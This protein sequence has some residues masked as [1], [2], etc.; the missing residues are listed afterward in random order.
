M[1]ILLIANTDWYLYNFRLR[2]A[3][4]LIDEG[5]DVFLV[6]PDGPYGKKLKDLGLN[7]TSAPMS[8][9]TNIFKDILFL[10][11]FIRYLR[12]NQ[13][14]FIHAFTIKPIIFSCIVTRI[15]S[16]IGLLNAIS[17]FGYL[18]SS[19]SRY[20]NLM[21]PAVSFCL[22]LVSRRS[23]VN[24]VLQNRSD[25]ETLGSLGL[26]PKERIH[27]IR[28]SGVNTSEF[29]PKITLAESRQVRVIM[30]CRLLWDK[31]LA[32]YFGAV[33]QLRDSGIDA[34]Y[35]LVGDIDEGNPNSASK[36]DILDLIGG[37]AVK[38]LG[39]VENM[40]ELVS[41]MDIMVLPTFY[42]E[43]VPRSLLEGAACS[44]ALVASDIA[45][46]KELVE[47]DVTGLLVPPRDSASLASALVRLISDHNLMAELGQRAR[48]KVKREFEEDLVI[49]QTL[50]LYPPLL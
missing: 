41:S 37:G 25:V 47:N 11:W 9:G 21:R 7:W 6:S 29:V 32:E 39:H 49:T 10:V 23:Y 50:R 46:C 16:N 14:N 24:W 35:F 15:F 31:G 22:K 20:A 1:K 42:G 27:L 28:G 17:G 44:L 13:I 34:E 30:A 3:Q 33:A 4:S 8:R 48:E 43:G 45:G 40:P 18:F 12:S 36:A 19:K 38:W 26:A 5:Y 2:L